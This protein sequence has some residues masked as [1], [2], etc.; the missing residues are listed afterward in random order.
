M[1]VLKPR[2]Y[3]QH[4]ACDNPPILV[5]ATRELHRASR[6]EHGVAGRAES[7]AVRVRVRAAQRVGSSLEAC[8]EGLLNFLPRKA[9]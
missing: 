4:E 9:A 2:G 6:R 8:L 1:G 3:T 5:F 7:N